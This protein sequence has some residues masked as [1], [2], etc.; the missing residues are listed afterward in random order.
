VRR[1]NSFGH[2]LNMQLNCEFKQEYK[3]ISK[4]GLEQG[5]TYLVHQVT[6]V[7]RY[8]AM[9]PNICGSSE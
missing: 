9:V 7:T 5:C 3:N 6:W 2:E 8:C 1:T 4:H